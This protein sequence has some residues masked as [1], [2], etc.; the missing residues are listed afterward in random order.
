MEWG[1]LIP[2]IIAALVGSYLLGGLLGGS[3]IGGLKGIDLRRHGSGNMGTTNVMRTMGPVYAL[4]TLAIDVSKGVAAVLLGRWAGAP[5]TPAV[6]G[7]LVIIG[8]NW[9]ISSSFRGGKGIAT[10]LGV[11]IVLAPKTLPVLVTLWLLLILCTGYVSLGSVTAL[12]LLP[13]AAFFLYRDADGFVW[14]SL[15]ALVAMGMG[16]LQHRENLVRLARG[17]EHKFI[18]RR[19]E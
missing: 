15:F 13:P 9:P 4:L 5:W 17:T 14:L 18:L 2:R 11:L 19:K 8:H 16:V 12:V 10:T 6:S 7:L 1:K 3:L